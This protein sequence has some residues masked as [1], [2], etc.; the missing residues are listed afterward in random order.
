MKPL[1]IISLLRDTVLFVSRA[2]NQRKSSG[3]SDPCG[4]ILLNLSMTTNASYLEHG[5]LNVKVDTKLIATTDMN[6]SE[7]ETFQ[8][9]NP[10][11][12]IKRE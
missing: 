8:Y 11:A 12:V 1:Q 10:C 4:F 6:I 2:G 9:C 5:S 7:F 3:K